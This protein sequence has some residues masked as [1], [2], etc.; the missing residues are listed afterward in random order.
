MSRG[1]GIKDVIRLGLLMQES[2]QGLSIQDIQKEFE[3]SRSTAIRMKK[4]L[5]DV[6]TVEEVE[7]NA[8][9]IKK[10][11]LSKKPFT[12]M[13]KFTAEEFAE[14][15]NCKSLMNIRR[16]LK[17]HPITKLF[18]SLLPKLLSKNV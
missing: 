10:W 6:F 12:K 5:E 9:P 3:V 13:I 16:I 15:E 4:V 8:S 17:S 18:L 1:D 7:N 2:F 14:L 11:R